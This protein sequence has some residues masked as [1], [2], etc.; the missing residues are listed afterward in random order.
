MEP[1]TTQAVTQTERRRPL[2][3]RL[4]W[5]DGGGGALVGAIVLVLHRPLA[6]WYGLPAGAVL[7]L[8]AANLAYGTYALSLARRALR[9]AGMLMALIAANAAWPLVCAA[10]LLAHLDEL[11]ALGVLHLVGEG[12]YVG[13]LA[14]VEWR[15]RDELR[16]R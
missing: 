3:R 15:L 1:G 10:I 6:G 9:P 13:G 16:S 7:L 5:I 8:G 14:A 2:A 11:R 12:L 4:L